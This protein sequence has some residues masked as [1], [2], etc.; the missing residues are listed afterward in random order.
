MSA[1]LLYFLRSYELAD[2]HKKFNIDYDDIMKSSAIDALKVSSHVHKLIK[3][4]SVTCSP[5]MSQGS[6]VNDPLYSPMK[7]VIVKLFKCY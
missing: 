6:H 5:D 3:I 7:M 4:R 1:I 2:L